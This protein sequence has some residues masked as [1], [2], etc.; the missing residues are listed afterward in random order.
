M[1]IIWPNVENANDENDIHENWMHR[2]LKCDC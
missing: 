1:E 2:Q